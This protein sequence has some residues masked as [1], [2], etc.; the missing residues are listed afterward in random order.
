MTNESDELTLHREQLNDILIDV[1]MYEDADLVQEVLDVTVAHYSKRSILLENARSVQLLVSQKRERQFRQIDIMLRDL[2]SNAETQ[3][4]WGNLLTEDDKTKSKQTHDIL[5]ELLYS[6]RS[7]REVLEFDEEFSPEKDVQDL[8]RNLGFFEIAWK[9]F[10]LTETLEE[11]EETG[12]LDKISK[13]TK[14][15]VRKC[16]ELM[17][18]FLLDNPTNQ[19]EGFQRLDFFMGTLDD[20]IDSHRVIRAIFR[21]NEYLM[22]KCPKEKIDKSIQ[23][24]VKN[25]RKPQ[26]LTLLNSV[27]YC[28]DKNIVENQFEVIKNVT[29][30]LPKV[31]KFICPMDTDEYREKQELMARHADEIDVAVDDLSEELAYHIYLIEV[32]S[33]CTVGRLNIT[34]IEAKVQSLY[35]YI[36]ILGAILDPATILIARIKLALHF[37]NSIVEVEMK[38]SG[39]DRSALVWKLLSTFPDVL[40][41]QR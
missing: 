29:A 8:L 23:N 38:V 7:R 32:L 2:E 30:K 20:E 15:I 34:S 26:Y 4:L 17:Y 1:A 37:F 35:A 28:G 14:E 31:L 3:E 36:D 40:M 11:D 21:N 24:I 39:L 9:V 13:N 22:K 5:G 19:A 27:T 12:E 16:N 18:W 41:E 25:G 33:G 6:V 10:D